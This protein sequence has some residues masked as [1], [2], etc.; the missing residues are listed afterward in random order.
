MDYNKQA[1]D[2]LESC[3]VLFIAEKA[4][5]QKS[6]RWSKDGKHGTHYSITLGKL[7]EKPS[8]TVQ[9]WGKPEDNLMH[10]SKVIEFSFWNS[11]HAKEKAEHTY[12]GSAKPRS[13]DVL[14]GV[15]M[16]VDSFDNFCSNFGY[17]TDSREAE[18]TYNEVVELNKKLE[19][20]FTS[21]ELERL[22]EIL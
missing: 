7:K 18:A 6:P 17:D 8:A 3:G 2:F 13:Y 19:S 14:A 10:C 9:Y 20:I 16:P 5:P 21:E 15:Y 12:N 11:L 1:K 4:I 22:Q